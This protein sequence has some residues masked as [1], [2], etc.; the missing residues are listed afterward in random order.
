[1]RYSII[2][3]IFAITHCK[4]QEYKRNNVWTLGFSPVATFNFSAVPFSLDTFNFPA[5][6]SNAC[7]SDTNGVLLFFTSGF[8]IFNGEGLLMANGINTNCPYDEHVL[9]DY[10]SHWSIFDQTSIILPKKGNTY[11]VFSTGMSDSVA[12]NYINHI[13]T[14]FD[15]LNYSIVDMDSN[16]GKGKVTIKNNILMEN[17]H[18][19]N[20]AMTA[21][22]HGNGK[23][24][25]LVKADCENNQYQTFIVQEDT[26]LGPYYHPITDTGDFCTFFSQIYFSDDGSKFASSMY[27]TIIDTTSPPFYYWNR[28]ETYDF[29]RCNGEFTFRNSYIVPYDTTTYPNYDY[30]TGI[31]FSPNGKLLYMSCR[32]SIYQVDIEDTNSTNTLLITGPDTTVAFPYY[33]TMA[34]GPDGKL[35]VGNSNGIR[36]Y[37]SFIDSPN[38]KGL[39]CH[40]V[41]NGVWQPYTNLL[42]PPNMPNYGLGKAPVGGNCWPESVSESGEPKSVW[43]LYPNPASTKIYFRGAERKKKRLYNAY[44]VLISETCKEEIDIKNLN[45]GLYFVQCNNL[46]KK[47]VIE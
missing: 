12:N 6:A 21:V 23:D 20:C 3:L 22:R 1:M 18:Y 34:C 37:M 45:R 16:A 14:E 8:A 13:K 9:A 4:A 27:G 43:V 44:G 26:I 10:Y 40:F 30:K 38:V 36:K 29:D 28:V 19:T 39:G 33:R 15:V 2:I 41:P 11:Y 32:Y 17:Q 35:Y 46:T 47:I 31:C 42:S 7:I 24:W 5:I 25:W